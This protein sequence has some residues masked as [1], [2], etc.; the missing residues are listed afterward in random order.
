MCKICKR[1]GFKNEHG[2]QI[3]M[4]K[5]H[6]HQKSPDQ[7]HQHN[8]HMGP[9]RDSRNHHRGPPRD[10]G[11]HH[12]GPPRDSREHPRHN[13]ARAM[14]IK[15]P[16]CDRDDFKSEG[17]LS[18]HIS[19]KH[20]SS[21]DGRGSRSSTGTRE[22]KEHGDVGAM[23]IKCR[24]CGKDDFKS[25]GGLSCHI[26]KMHSGSAHGKGSRPSSCTNGKRDDGARPKTHTPHHKEP[27]RHNSDRDVVKGVARV[28]RDSL[29][30]GSP[31]EFPLK[32]GPVGARPKS[33]PAKHR[34]S[35]KQSRQ[36]EEPY[37]RPSSSASNFSL[38]FNAPNF[39]KFVAM[40]EGSIIR[41]R[42][43][44]TLRTDS[45]NKFIDDLKVVM[46][47]RSDIPIKLLK[48]GSY[49]DRTKI[50]Y[51]DEF[52]F[53]FYPDIRMEAD[54]S[55][56]PPGYCKIRKGK[57]VNPDLDPFIDRDG[58][59]VPEL[60]KAHMVDI[61]EKC[62]TDSSFRKG[63]RTQ[64]QDRKPESPAFTLLFDLGISDKSPIDIDLVPAIRIDDWPKTA[65][66]I[67]PSKWI[68][69]STAEKAMQCFHVVTKRFPEAHPNIHL[70]WRVSFSHAEKGLILHAD[71]SDNGCRKDVF[72]YLKKIKENIKSKNPNEMDKFCSYHLKMFILD[73]FDKHSD[74][75][76]E[77]K[78]DLLKKSIKELAKC[79]SNGTIKN[80]FFSRDNVLQSVPEKER[81]YV[82]RELEGLL[83]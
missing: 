45:I 23:V 11:E 57:T 73:F 4:A 15:C 20:P 13:D 27:E 43:D 8:H 68:E 1:D 34:E 82:V 28:Q 6:G 71:K 41:P 58:Y 53:M 39:E 81:G 25:E 44:S 77:R 18:N 67:H 49:Y 19:W 38:S 80:Y 14:V 35:P 48:S 16:I 55:N 32:D 83:Q 70:L 31:D 51:N 50:D 2:L 5:E 78:L 46:E 3:H 33:S 72:K 30:R 52:D 59:L 37:D 40:I 65:R 22:R 74:F 64:I 36:T 61:F 66:E 76:K 17:G 79:V 10:S 24:I 42:E 29:Q 12:T 54:F 47:R 9:P 75:S 56:C 62:R 7:R 60:Y 26:T 63:R 21:T 69:K